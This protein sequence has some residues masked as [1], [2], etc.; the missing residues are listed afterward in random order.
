M[1]QQG[2]A[3]QALSLTQPM[4][5]WAPP[6]LSRRL[7][8][9]FND[10]VAQAHEDHSDRLVGLAIIPMQHA[11]TALLELDRVA[12]LP[13]IRGVY[14]ATCVGG[15]DLSDQSFWPIFERVEDLGLPISVSQIFPFKPPRKSV[16]HRGGCQPP[17]IRRCIG[18]LSETRLR[19]T[20][21]RRRFT[22]PAR[23]FGA[24]MESASRVSAPTSQPPRVPIALLLRHHHALVRGAPLLD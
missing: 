8:A 23:P 3:V 20:S 14:M 11:E 15:K 9:T 13:G 19:P 12:K 16:R 5:Y 24:W 10:A 2:V 1:D 22:L 7:S 18:P 21:W 17:H 6:A 4:V